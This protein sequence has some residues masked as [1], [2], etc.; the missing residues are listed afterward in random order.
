MYYLV[1]FYNIKFLIKD[2]LIY[3]IKVWYVIDNKLLMKNWILYIVF[4]IE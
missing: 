3:Y 1:L 4:I 2:L